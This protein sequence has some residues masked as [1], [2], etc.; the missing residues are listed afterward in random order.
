MEHT[1][2]Q[3]GRYIASVRS[4]A[5]ADRYQV[6][7]ERWLEWLQRSG[8]DGVETAPRS[9]LSE[10]CVALVDAGYLPATVQAHI[11]GV[12]RYLKWLKKQEVEVPDFHDP[13]IPR[14][15]RKVRDSLDPEKLALYFKVA[16]Q[17]DEP[18]RTA[19][20]LLP[21]CGLRGGE[22]VKL[23]LV[24][25]V[26]RTQVKLQD[27][28]VKKVLCLKL[29]GKGGHERVVPVF[30][31]GEEI[32]RGYL[33]H[34]RKGNPDQKWLFPGRKL[35]MSDRTLRAALQQ[36]REPL[37]MRFTPHTMRRT[38]LTSLFRKGA[39]TALIAKI[40]GHTNIKTLI[41]HY[42][43]LSEYDIA[44]AFQQTGGSLTE[45]T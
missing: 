31:E 33:N 5:T 29:T 34:W 40:A 10:Y 26:S 11:A 18:V 7:A 37:G 4:P 22:I 16:D 27:G 19:A 12:K 28:T 36:V 20:M 25:T 42:L 43:D 13:E 23:P 14:H 39:D 35:H 24:G 21:C 15:T 3:F 8:V 30:E 41:D 6:S 45:P 38:Y 44:K 17:L 1:L 32:L 2:V 9:A